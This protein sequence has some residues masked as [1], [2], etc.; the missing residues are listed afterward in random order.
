MATLAAV[1]RE[2]S[3]TLELPALLD[4]IAGLACELLEAGTSAVYLLQPDGLTLK[5]IAAQGE[6]AAQ[7]LADETS[8]GKGIVGSIVENGRQAFDKLSKNEH[9]LMLLDSEMPVMN[10]YQ[11]LEQLAVDRH[12]RNVPVV[13]VSSLEELD[14]VV[15]CIEM[16]AEDYLTKPDHSPDPVK[17]P[18]PDSLPA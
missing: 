9:D 4:R 15:R 6:V 2:I 18:L 14:S 16:G 1:G 17:A 13:V 3:A 5:A 11:V 10:G 8:L 12:L 7:I